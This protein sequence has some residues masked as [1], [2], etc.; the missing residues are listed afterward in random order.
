MQKNHENLFARLRVIMI[1]PMY[2]Y[3]VVGGMERQAHELSKTLH[4]KDIEIKVLSTK[5]SSCDKSYELVEN[6]PVYRIVLFKNR[7][8]RFFIG[9]LSLFYYLFKFRKSFD[10]VHTHE[11]GWFS[12]LS[13]FIAKILKKATISKLPNIGEKGIPGLGSGLIGSLKRSML[14]SS[15]AIV[16]MS[17]ES[18]AELKSVKFPLSRVLLTPNGIRI[19]SNS[20]QDLAPKN[21]LIPR[22]VFVGRLVPQKGI[23][24]LLNA[25][26][27]LKNKSINAELEIFGDGPLY[28]D[29]IKN[30]LDL[31]VAD[32]VRFRGHINNVSDR[33]NEM[34]VFVLPSY[35]EGNSNAL[36]E[37]MVTGLPIVASRVG[38]APMQ[39]GYEGRDYLFSPGNKNELA[40]V[41]EKLLINDY[42]RNKLGEE[43]KIRASKYFDIQIVSDTYISAYK[44]LKKHQ[45][46]KMAELASPV[47]TGNQ[48]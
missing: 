14:L 20:V 21:S 13:I 16:A 9:S 29:L 30:S 35:I 12:L 11:I 3:P 27:I 10:V 18:L 37:A 44:A 15:D 7:F 25:W 23:K 32:S 40:M 24:D 2:P 6:I 45:R 46:E 19:E 33:L 5:H 38:G 39:V 41:L 42:L 48:H 31:G 4:D 26:K 34:D 1:L 43:M 8:L 47:I 36:L 22:V 17:L 28:Q